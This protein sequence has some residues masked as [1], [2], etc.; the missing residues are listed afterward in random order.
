MGHDRDHPCA[1]GPIVLD[2]P[3]ASR[4]EV[5]LDGEVVGFADYVEHGDRVELPHTV[6]DRSMRGQGLAALLVQRVLDE[7]R[8]QDRRVVPTCWY[9]AQFIDTH[10]GYDEILHR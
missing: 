4:Y 1:T 3:G 10:A 2:N 9:V 6:I 8:A 5:L 7:L